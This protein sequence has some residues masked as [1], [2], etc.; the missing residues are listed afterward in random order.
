MIHGEKKIKS[1]KKNWKP[2]KLRTKLSV[3]IYSTHHKKSWKKQRNT[4]NLFHASLSLSR[5]FIYFHV[6]SWSINS[7][8]VRISWVY[9]CSCLHL[10][11]NLIF[12]YRIFVFFFPSPLSFVSFV[13][14]FHFFV[15]H[16]I[17]WKVNI[18]IVFMTCRHSSGILTFLFP[19]CLSFYKILDFISGRSVWIY[20]SQNHAIEYDFVAK[21]WQCH[22][23]AFSAH[24]FSTTFI[25]WTK[26]ASENEM[27]RPKK[28]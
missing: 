16:W 2:N 6:H 28:K 18:S 22:V 13:F 26:N 20:F 9:Y 21:K 14:H 8:K 5:Q 27:N 10:Q 15:S 19:Y 25:H 7:N 12:G 11:F 4:T 23:C 17:L 3:I 1:R 24:K